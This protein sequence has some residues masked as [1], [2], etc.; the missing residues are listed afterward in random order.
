MVTKTIM[1]SEVEFLYSEFLNTLSVTSQRNFAHIG[2]FLC[3][4]LGSRLMVSM[5]EGQHV[6]LYRAASGVHICCNICSVLPT[7]LCVPTMLIT[8]QFRF[9]AD[10]PAICIG[11][12]VIFCVK[13]LCRLICLRT[14]K[15]IPGQF[16]C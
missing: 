3:G 9:L 15:A 12:K 5:G 7:L 1:R 10:F 11:V 4:P 13:R 16:R 6:F 8:Q 14:S 2:Y